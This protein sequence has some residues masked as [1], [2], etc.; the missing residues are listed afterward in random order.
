[1]VYSDASHLEDGGGDSCHKGHLYLSVETEVLGGFFVKKRE[2][3][4]KE[5]EGGVE[6]FSPCRR[7]WSIPIRQSGS[8]VCVLLASRPPGSTVEGQ[9]IPWS[10]DA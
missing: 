4:N 6:K 7:A 3:Q 2:E 1:M 9:Q 8:V 10:W 5:M